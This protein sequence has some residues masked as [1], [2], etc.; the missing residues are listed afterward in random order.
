MVCFI[1]TY[2]Y[3]DMVCMATA[4]AVLHVCVVC[5]PVLGVQV[6]LMLPENPTLLVVF[7]TRVL[8]L[9]CCLFII[10]P[11]L[12]THQALAYIHWTVPCLGITKLHAAFGG[13]ATPFA[14]HVAG[15]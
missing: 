13:P 4:V 6:H 11:P 5:L 3:L 15:M 2:R 8:F 10:S 14:L 9:S 12:A 7:F 1:V